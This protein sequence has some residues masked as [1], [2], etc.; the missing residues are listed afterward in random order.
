M[1][2]QLIYFLVIVMAIT[3]FSCSKDDGD[4]VQEPVKSNAKQITGFVFKASENEAITADVTA[5]I[6]EQSK[7]IS[8]AV[9]DGTIITSLKSTLQL[10]EKAIVDQTGA[11]DFSS[12]IDYSVTAEDGTK[13]TYTLTVTISL[14]DAKQ[15]TSFIFYNDESESLDEDVVSTIDEVNK[16]LTAIV[17]LNTN[18]AILVPNIKIS[19][20]ATITPEG[21]QDFTNAIPYTVTAENGTEITY[22]VTVTTELSSKKQIISFVYGRAENPELLEDVE[23]A[24]D[25]ERKQILDAIPVYIKSSSL[26]PTIEISE[27]ATLTKSQDFY[28]VTAEDGSTQDYAFF[29]AFIAHPR[30]VLIELFRDNP[31]NTLNW[32]LSEKD[33]STWEGVTTNLE[34]NITELQLLGK[35]LIELPENFGFL[36]ALEK[37]NL[38]LNN[39]TT[40]PIEFNRLEALTTLQLGSNKFN[41]LPEVLWDLET[42]IELDLSN[43]E[44]TTLPQEIGQ[45]NSLITLILNDNEISNFPNS[46]REISTLRRL[47]LRRNNLIT[48]P[49]EIFDIEKLE[50]LDLLENQITGISYEIENLTELNFLRLSDNTIRSIPSEIAALTK[51][52]RLYVANNDLVN[53]SSGLGRL[54]NIEILDLNGNDLFSIPPEIGNLSSLLLLDLRNNALTSI[55]QSICE[56]TNAGSQVHLDAGVLC[57]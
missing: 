27:G 10:S 40:L 12:P 41:E 15:I 9:P 21:M 1:K 47:F 32:N 39:L 5:V 6:N 8:A 7:T 35:N 37:L 31:G 13:I 4:V 20:N 14:S 2:K 23:V 22:T 19:P 33:L 52:K 51:L 48:I 25:E 38:N 16:I 46:L 26:L 3:S 56:L 18:R 50:Y 54:A 44:L 30:Y 42:L 55:P 11:K 17:P 49:K 29:K 43:L 28:T 24:I 34:G 53:I 36:N 45:L 57:Q